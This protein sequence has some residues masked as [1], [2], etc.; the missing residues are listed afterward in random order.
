MQR[1]AAIIF[2]VMAAAVMPSWAQYFVNN[3]AAPAILGATDRPFVTLSG[4]LLVPEGG[5][6]QPQPRQPFPQLPA[7]PVFVQP[8]L[9]S[10][11][12][13]FTPQPQRVSPLLTPFTFRPT[14]SL[15]NHAAKPLVDEVVDGRAYHFSW[16]HDSGRLYTW[17]QATYY[18]S[19]LGNGF[20]AVSI[21]SH[22]KQELISNYMIT[23]YIS[24]I[25]TSGNKRNSRS[26]SWLSGTSSPYSNWSSTGRRGL[27]QPDNDEGNEDCLAVLNNLYNDGVTWHDS[28]CFHL[29]RVI[30]E[31]PRFYAQ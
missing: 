26:W 5:P 3:N 15:C 30:C 18:C 9:P 29:R 13:V 21:E 7:Q 17:E 25:W 11:P 20:Q 22:R 28:S 12:Q 14:S 27:P 31:A 4:N 16:C 8:Q 23:H 19:G 24:D 10:L 2:L 1:M 6:T